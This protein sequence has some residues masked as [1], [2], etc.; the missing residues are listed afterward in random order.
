MLILLFFS[1]VKLQLLR[2]VCRDTPYKVRGFKKVYDEGVSLFIKVSS[3]HVNDLKTFDS[4][5]PENAKHMNLKVANS[6]LEYSK[7]ATNL[8]SQRRM[9][10][11]SIKKA[12]AKF[13]DELKE[14][15]K[16]RVVTNRD[17]D[18]LRCLK[19][20][21]EFSRDAMQAQRTFG[22]SIVI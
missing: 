13:I 5:V 18:A 17:N 8:M 14:M 20:V 16:H 19:K 1:A 6:Y 21:Y 9:S 10:F 4:D 15:A 12:L 22:L 3:R 7:I 2:N 11:D